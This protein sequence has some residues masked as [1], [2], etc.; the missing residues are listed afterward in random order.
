M[1]F[2]HKR[3]F[4]NSLKQVIQVFFNIPVNAPEPLT[5]YASV[6]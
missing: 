4:T 3:R 5:Q 6:R 2:N 1:A